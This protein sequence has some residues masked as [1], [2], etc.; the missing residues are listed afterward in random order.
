MNVTAIVSAYYA[1]KYIKGR[2]ENLLTQEPTPEIIVVAQRGSKEWECAKEFEVD[3]S[4]HQT[5]KVITTDGVPT[6][7]KAWNI[8]IK[9]A[10]GEICT[11]ANS[12]DRLKPGAIRK[13][14]EAFEADPEVGIVFFNCD[15]A[16][17]GA[18]RPWKRIPAETGIWKEALPT[19]C[20]RSCIGPM[21][22]WRKDLG[23][24]DERFKQACDYEFFL[25]HAMNGET[26]YYIDEYLG[27]YLN[28]PDSDEHKFKANSLREDRIIKE[29]YTA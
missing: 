2:L 23:L 3:F 17:D 28:R 5:V 26:F 20:K 1:E 29:M 12:D 27:I 16:V 22:F 10:K 9:A 4:A 13:V 24:Y 7:P 25:R 8:G 6:I 15:M 19:L 18:V 21:P 11:N 14:V